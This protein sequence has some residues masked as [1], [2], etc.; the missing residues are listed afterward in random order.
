MFVI[1]FIKSLKEK[2]FIG[3]LLKKI[4]NIYIHAFFLTCFLH[5]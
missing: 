2:N 5:F 4:E 3:T 1:F